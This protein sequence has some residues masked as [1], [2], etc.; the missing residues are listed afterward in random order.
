ME[1]K[2]GEVKIVLLKKRSRYL[3]GGA[4]IGIAVGFV[5][6][7]LMHYCT[8][9]FEIPNDGG[10][11]SEN[12]MGCLL[13][14]PPTFLLTQFVDN[15]VLSLILFSVINATIGATVGWTLYRIVQKSDQ[16]I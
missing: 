1:S 14:L 2:D 5:L 8:S 9:S 4:L 15:I 11:T 6:L 10:Y 16:K 3:V 13:L 12:V 7:G